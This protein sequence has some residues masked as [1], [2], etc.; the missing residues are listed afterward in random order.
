MTPPKPMRGIVPTRQAVGPR[1]AT[2]SGAAR[3]GTGPLDGYRLTR[4]LICCSA[5]GSSMVVRS[6]GSR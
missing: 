2:N 3:I 1:N 6:P 5:A 4:S